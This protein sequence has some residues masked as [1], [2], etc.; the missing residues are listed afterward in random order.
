[1][2]QPV[3]CSTGFASEIGFVDGV[4]RFGSH[5]YS[6]VAANIRSIAPASTAPIS[7]APTWRVKSH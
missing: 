5:T 7:H 2:N 3:Q 6:N 4:L 1:L